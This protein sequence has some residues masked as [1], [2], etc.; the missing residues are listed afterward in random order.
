MATGGHPLPRGNAATEQPD[1]PI[2]NAPARLS[3][4]QT[5]YIDCS[6]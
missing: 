2:A 6:R 4:G 1:S 5:G 3:L